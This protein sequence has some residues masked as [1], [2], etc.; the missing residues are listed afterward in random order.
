[1]LHWCHAQT[2]YLA[3]Y[4]QEQQH[5]LQ[6]NCTP[7]KHSR[8]GER[9]QQFPFGD[10]SSGM[11]GTPRADRTPRELGRSAV[12]TVAP[13][14]AERRNQSP[15]RAPLVAA[16]KQPAMAAPLVVVVVVVVV[17]YLDVRSVLRTEAAE[18]VWEA[19]VETAVETAV[20]A[21]VE[22]AVEVAVIAALVEAEANLS[23][24]PPWDRRCS[25]CRPVASSAS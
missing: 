2:Q 9:L 17:N 20:V 5:L 12:A 16:Q 18:A 10:K 3:Y 25:C 7:V 1:M 19:P 21:A 11:E 14:L 23:V 6:N 22:S 8:V 15:T 4:Q 24:P 13:L